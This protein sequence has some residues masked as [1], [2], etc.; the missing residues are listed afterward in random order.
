M[1]IYTLF[2]LQAK[3]LDI[4]YWKRS[5]LLNFACFW[6]GVYRFQNIGGCWTRLLGGVHTPNTPLDLHPY[7][8]PKQSTN[9]EIRNRSKKLGFRESGPFSWK[10]KDSRVFPTS[11]YFRCEAPCQYSWIHIMCRSRAI[12]LLRANRFIRALARAGIRVSTCMYTSSS[13]GSS[14]GNHQ[15]PLPCVLHPFLPFSIAQITLWSN[16]SYKCTTLHT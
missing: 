8:L 10:P 14:G 11:A 15:K 7:R 16:M 5:I 2:A 9:R 12:I 13:G 1:I 3:I 4:S 6:V